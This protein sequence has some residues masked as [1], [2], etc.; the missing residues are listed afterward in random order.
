VAE[1][2][3]PA[4]TTYRHSASL[5]GPATPRRWRQPARRSMP[6]I[7]RARLLGHTPRSTATTQGLRDSDALSGGPCI[8]C[9]TAYVYQAGPETLSV[10]HGSRDNLPSGRRPVPCATQIHAPA[11][12]VPTAP[13]H[14]A[15]AGP[16]T[17]TT[18]GTTGPSD[19]RYSKPPAG[20]ATP[21]RQRQ[22][23]LQVAPI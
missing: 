12:P 23:A 15:R 2:T 13:D 21:L 20:P 14:S 9:A 8:R 18:V 4:E 7:R 17:L 19:N 5:V 11:A 3:G 6:E 1:T 10:T 16:A 22:P